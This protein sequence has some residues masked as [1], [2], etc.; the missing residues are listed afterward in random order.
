MDELIAIPCYPYTVHCCLV[1]DVLNCSG[2]FDDSALSCLY[3]LPHCFLCVTS[4]L[5]TRFVFLLCV[6][7]EEASEFTQTK[8]TICSIYMEGY[9]CVQRKYIWNEKFLPWEVYSSMKSSNL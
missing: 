7:V 2:L 5:S 9:S 4:N 1:L 8:V 3:H 6:S